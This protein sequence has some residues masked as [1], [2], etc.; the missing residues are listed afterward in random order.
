MSSTLPGKLVLS[1]TFKDQM[2]VVNAL[3]DVLTTPQ[4]ANVGAMAIF[5]DIIDYNISIP[6]N[7]R[8][9]AINVT[10]NSGNV[11]TVQPGATF[12]VL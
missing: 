2:D 5:D 1:N 4:K 11:V 10:I 8:A 9:L 6:S 3:I 7:K 12:V